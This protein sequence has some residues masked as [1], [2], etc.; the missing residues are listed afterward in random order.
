MRGRAVKI[1]GFAVKVARHAILCPGKAHSIVVKLR[2]TLIPF[3]CIALA[4]RY[5]FVRHERCGLL[6]I[7]RIVVLPGLNCLACLSHDEVE[8]L[9]LTTD[10]GPPISATFAS[11]LFLHPRSRS[12]SSFGTPIFVSN[13][14][15]YLFPARLA[16][17]PSKPHNK[18]VTFAGAE[19]S[20]Q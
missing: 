2:M 4:L 10:Q 19:F 18:E 1:Q 7:L 15:P 12:P 17:S 11:L 13:I 5:E 16:S 20:S 14:I 8:L 9:G 3:I 6:H